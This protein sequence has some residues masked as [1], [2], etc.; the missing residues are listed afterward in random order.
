M[1]NLFKNLSGSVSYYYSNIAKLRDKTQVYLQACPK[2]ILYVSNIMFFGF[3]SDC[4][5]VLL[6]ERKVLQVLKL[7]KRIEMRFLNL[8]YLIG[9]VRIKHYAD[10]SVFSNLLRA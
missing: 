8:L 10:S 6:M 7:G 9:F 3:A 4:F 1:L 5:M 2:C